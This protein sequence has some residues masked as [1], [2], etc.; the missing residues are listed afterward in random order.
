M[1][2]KIL[3]MLR[4]EKKLTQTELAQKT[5]ID[6]ALIS[7]FESGER[8]PNVEKLQI[9]TEYYDVSV[10]FVLGRTNKREVNR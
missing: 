2:E 4:K 1:M 8:V 5:G 3:K 6:Q 9:L 7:K 10:D